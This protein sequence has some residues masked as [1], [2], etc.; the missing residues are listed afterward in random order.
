MRELNYDHMVLPMDVYI[1]VHG[2]KV[3]GEIKKA[4]ALEEGGGAGPS[5]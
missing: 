2:F 5:S 1:Q 4:R 3:P